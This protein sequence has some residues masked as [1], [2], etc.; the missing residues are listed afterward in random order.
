MD[1]LCHGAYEEAGMY[2]NIQ[3]FR[4]RLYKLLTAVLLTSFKYLS[5]SVIDI[6]NLPVT[7]IRYPLGGLDENA[8]LLLPAAG[9]T[10]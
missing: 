5:H 9:V 8:L 1:L 6:W 10:Y 7:Y 3:L 2:G 4:G